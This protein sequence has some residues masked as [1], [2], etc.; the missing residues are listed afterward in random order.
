[1]KSS[2]QKTAKYILIVFYESECWHF[3]MH[4]I[5]YN[6]C[7]FLFI[8]TD[9]KNRNGG[10]NLINTIETRNKPYLRLNNHGKHSHSETLS[11][12]EIFGR[13][14]LDIKSQ[15]NQSISHNKENIDST[16]DSEDNFNNT[17]DNS[18]HNGSING[19]FQNKTTASTVKPITVKEETIAQA[20][21]FLTD[22]LHDGYI[23]FHLGNGQFL[24]QPSS[25][26]SGVIAAP[27]IIAVCLGTCLCGYCRYKCR[28]R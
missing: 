5:M 1:M 2:A 9:A 16:V 23:P 26:K 13:K 18:T 22:P 28:V 24:E 21:L 11:S 19:Y 3:K 6:N 14:L 25:L 12:L 10:R 17:S 15:V 8:I 7:D 20:N 4:L 27:V